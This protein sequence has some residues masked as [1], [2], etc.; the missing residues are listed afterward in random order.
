MGH[1]QARRVAR[2]RDCRADRARGWLTGDAA[3]RQVHRLRAGADAIAVGIG[4]ALSDDPA[5]TV[6]GV[7][8]P[9]VTPLRVV[10]DRQARLPVDSPL[11]RTAR[12]VPTLI[13]T[14]TATADAPA[15]LARKGVEVVDAPTLEAA[16]Q[17]LH[18]RGVHHLLVEGGA[19][20]AGALL[21]HN[22][23]DRLVI[24]EAPVILGAGA[25]G[26]FSAVPSAVTDALPR[27]RVIERRELGDDLMTVLAPPGA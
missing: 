20:L 3:R 16:L 17:A 4:T 23:V 13:V 21:A 14:A 5:L 8:K 15:A 24:F 7:R 1:P 19:G 6:R 26:A 9:R 18:G 12:R 2:R 22:L 25:L 27:W 10:F 11:V